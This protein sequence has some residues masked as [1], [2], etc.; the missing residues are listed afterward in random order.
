MVKERALR[1]ATGIERYTYASSAM[2]TEVSKLR[3]R[4]GYL[5]HT[6]INTRSRSAHPSMTETL[7][8]NC[9]LYRQQAKTT[10]TVSVD[11]RYQVANNH[12]GHEVR[13]LFVRAFYVNFY[14]SQVTA[15]TIK[16]KKRHT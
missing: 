16:K 7:H 8:N 9:I 12:A 4:L 6:D 10:T 15:D 11:N 3:R 1:S 5:Q 14:L 13:T 2:L